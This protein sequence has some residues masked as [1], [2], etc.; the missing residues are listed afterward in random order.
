MIVQLAPPA[1]VPPVTE[2]V[3]VAAV[4]VKVNELPAAG[5]HVA[6][7]DNASTTDR[8]AGKTSVNA[9]PLKAELTLGLAMV[10]IRL[11]VSFCLIEGGSKTLE[12]VGGLGFVLRQPRKMTLSRTT[13]AVALLEPSAVIRKVVRVKPEAGAILV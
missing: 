7:T 4:V 11:D 1:S 3:L 8:P 13:R 10:K 9:T 6:G 2:R 12:I 5:T